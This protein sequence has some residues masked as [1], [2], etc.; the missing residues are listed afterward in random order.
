MLKPEIRGDVMDRSGRHERECSGTYLEYNL[1]PS[2]AVMLYMLPDNL[3]FDLI[4]TTV[5]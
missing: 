1:T 4:Q 5:L 3:N 2:V